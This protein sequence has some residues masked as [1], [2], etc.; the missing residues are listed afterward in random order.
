MLRHG[1]LAIHANFTTSDIDDFINKDYNVRI[2]ADNSL[3]LLF[4]CAIM[5]FF[6]FYNVL[7]VQFT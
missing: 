6:F 4:L 7:C 5:C 3:F 2:C 1:I